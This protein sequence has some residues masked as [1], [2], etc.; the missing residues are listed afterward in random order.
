MGGGEGKPTVLASSKHGFY[1]KGGFISECTYAPAYRHTQPMN[2]L[3]L[4]ESLLYPIGA[5]PPPIK[6]FNTNRMLSRMFCLGQYPELM[7]RWIRKSTS[8]FKNTRTR[9]SLGRIPVKTQGAIYVWHMFMAFPH[10][11]SNWLFREG[12]PHKTAGSSHL[13]PVYHQKTRTQLCQEEQS[14]RTLDLTRF[15]TT[16]NHSRFLLKSLNHDG[17][18]TSHVHL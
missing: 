15:S 18:W 16:E 9:D 12:R 10:Q 5:P 2:H 11:W 7:S 17:V 1:C 6:A 8:Q 4:W 13:T 14:Y 3:F